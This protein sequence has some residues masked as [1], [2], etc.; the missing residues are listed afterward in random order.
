MI[1]PARVVLD[2]VRHLA[3]V[4]AYDGVQAALIGRAEGHQQREVQFL[5]A[6]ERSLDRLLGIDI[7]VV[8]D[9][10]QPLGELLVL[11]RQ[12]AQLR[13]VIRAAFVDAHLRLNFIGQGC[14][15]IVQLV[16][17]VLHVRPRKGR[18]AVRKAPHKHQ[19][20]QQYERKYHKP[21]APAAAT[22][23]VIAPRRVIIFVLIVAV[24]VIWQAFH[25]RRLY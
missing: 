2:E 1:A 14:Q 12:S 20:Q 8:G 9:E 10:V 6:L 23:P 17:H 11:L 15:G 21:H 19:R 18:E 25:L 5:S 24:V 3:L 22:A 7:Y 13:D 4:H 16:L